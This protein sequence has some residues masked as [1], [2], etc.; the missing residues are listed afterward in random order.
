MKLI[1]EFNLDDCDLQ[2]LKDIIN[3]T[4]GEF[5]I[6]E[7]DVNS[8]NNIFN[9]RFINSFSRSPTERESLCA[10]VLIYDESARLDFERSY[11]ME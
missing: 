9:S 11:F 6:L 2:R 1:N 7:I 8:V 5:S 4:A 3:L 10:E